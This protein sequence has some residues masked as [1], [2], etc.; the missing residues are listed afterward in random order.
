MSGGVPG[1]CKASLPAAWQVRAEGVGPEPAAPT[2]GPRAARFAR[3]RFLGEN[4]CLRK[5]WRGEEG[6]ALSFVSL[7]RSPRRRGHTAGQGTETALWASV[8][9]G[10]EGGGARSA[11]WAT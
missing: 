11:V 1:R 8:L 5:G 4:S 7:G 6:G 2:P 10:G 3:R 9:G